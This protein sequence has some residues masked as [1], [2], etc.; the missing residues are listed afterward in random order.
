MAD[1]IEVAKSLP[2]MSNERLNT[3]SRIRLISKN[4]SEIQLG[5]SLIY[6]RRESIK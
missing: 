1:L 2:T 3:L 4:Q 5:L 6:K